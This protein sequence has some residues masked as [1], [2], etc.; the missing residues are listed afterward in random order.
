M[1]KGMPN[2]IFRKAA[3]QHGIT[4]CALI[5]AAVSTA[6]ADGPPIAM[7][8]PVTESFFG[9]Q[10]SD[11]YRWMEDAKSPEFQ[12]YMKQQSDWTRRT[13]DKIPGRDA[14]EKRI[15]VLDNTAT[16]IR[17][18]Q[19]AGRDYFYLKSKPGAKNY[20]LVMR[21]G[22]SGK[23]HLLV[24]PETLSAKGA[25]NASSHLS[26]DYFQPSLDGSLVAYALSAGGSEQSTLHIMTTASGKDLPD[27]IDRTNF[28][29]VSWSED[30]KSF[31]YNR[32]VKLADG[33][34]DT[35]K[36]KNSIVY[37]H[38]LGQDPE[39]DKPVLVGHAKAGQELSSIGSR[40]PEKVAGL[41]YLD[42]GYSYAFYDSKHGDLLL[43]AIDLRKKLDVYLSAS[44]PDLK[45]YFTDLQASLPQFGRDVQDFQDELALMPAQPPRTVAPPPIMVA[46]GAGAQ[47]YTEIHAPVLAIFADPHNLGQFDADNPQERQK[48]I[49]DDFARTTAQADAFQAGIPGSRVVRIP[50]ASHMIFESN[51]ADVLREMNAFMAKLP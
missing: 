42:A 17:D 24:D 25:D 6:W 16:L 18:M 22:E 38:V 23:E 31:F 30:G 26:I 44:A 45:Q 41:V 48:L 12:T 37:Q 20:A 3:R 11:P 39:I 28:G 33:Q 4:A 8:K 9:T 10:V 19:F 7:Q 21:V 34:A 13:L 40:H 36:Y 43:D 14:L 35:D 51:E 32:L 2:F 46:I 1:W 5:Y 15:V 47:K 49:L 50:N 29:D 27:L